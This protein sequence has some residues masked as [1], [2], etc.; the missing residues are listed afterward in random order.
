MYNFHKMG[1]SGQNSSFIKNICNW[2]Y[3][4][5]NLPGV[6]DRS[7]SLTSHQNK[8]LCITH[9]IQLIKVKQKNFTPLQD[10]I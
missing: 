6:V 1:I 10:L 2:E 7:L 3:R 5:R 9:S 4:K 8:Q